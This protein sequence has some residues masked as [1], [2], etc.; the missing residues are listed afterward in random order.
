MSHAAGHAIDP[1]PL[2][3][4][5]HQLLRAARAG[6][7]NALAALWDG[8]VDELWSIAAALVGPDAALELL[9]DVRGQVRDRAPGLAVDR[10]FR[11][12]AIAL[13]WTA[14]RQAHGMGA[15]SDAAQAPPTAPARTLAQGLSALPIELR[16]VYLLAF[17]AGLH[18]A[19]IAALCDSDE[20]TVRALR[21][22]AAWALVA[23][24]RGTP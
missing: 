22:R 20:G 11:L 17:L 9:A 21:A 10:S 3:L 24:T 16:W 7:P 23:S 5:E 4:R 1:A 15:L 13:L 14:L 18:S 8:C 2:E 12:Q 19:Q 6:E